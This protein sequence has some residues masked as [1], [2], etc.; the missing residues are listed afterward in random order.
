MQ[1]LK[2]FWSE[3]GH[4]SKA[5]AV[6]D[7]VVVNFRS[8]HL[9][10]DIKSWK[11]RTPVVD[12]MS[13]DR[14]VWLGTKEDFKDF[15]LPEDNRQEISVYHGIDAYK[16]LLTLASGMNSVK[17][18]ETNIN[19]QIYDG[20]ER[21]KT[22]QP[23]KA[24]FL[25]TVMQMVRADA[26]L[27]LDGPAKGIESPDHALVAKNLS[28]MKRGQKVLIIGSLNRHGQ[29]SE[30]TEQIARRVML[31]FNKC[32]SI[33]VMHPDSVTAVKLQIELQK[34]SNHLKTGI[35]VKARP[36]EEVTEILE[37]RPN[38]LFET[39]DQ[40]YIDMPMG[41]YP[42]AE[43][44]IIEAWQGRENKTNYMTHLRGAP[45]LRGASNDLWRN[46][47]LDNYV[48]PEDIK[49]RKDFLHENNEVMKAKALGLIEFIS[50]HRAAGQNMSRSVLRNFGATPT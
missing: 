46:A 13:C 4:N 37:G 8:K 35:N 16:F 33:K 36:F 6:G 45:E 42:E 50:Q 14:Q 20:W 17:A 1:T 10:E 3:S 39:R 26:R 47:R 19:G 41:S 34:V 28:G 29:L 12:I 7:L 11:D 25:D 32:Q 49:A 9:S 40:V 2:A 23:S 48:S 27:I 18:G 44:V 5:R 15:P 21:F 31:E 22:E 30:Y 38:R 43:K 24:K